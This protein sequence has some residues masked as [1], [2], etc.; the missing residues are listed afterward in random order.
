MS[1]HSTVTAYI[2]LGSNL[3]DRAH[4]ILTAITKLTNI[5]GISL[6]RISSIID[7]PAVGGPTDAPPF[8][9]GAVEVQTTLGSHNLLHQLLDIEKSMGRGE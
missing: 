7:N 9:N 2:A 5:D 4:H 3:G 1:N 8:L 6:K